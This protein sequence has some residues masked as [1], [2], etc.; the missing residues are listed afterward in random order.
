MAADVLKWAV[1]AVLVASL[2]A[3][4]YTL[5]LRDD[6]D[7]SS[8]ATP[9]PTEIPLRTPPIE[10]QG[11]GSAEAAMRLELLPVGNEVRLRWTA[12]GTVRCSLP[13]PGVLQITW[14]GQPP[15]DPP[16]MANVTRRFRV[17]LDLP[18]NDI[19]GEWTWSNWCGSVG[20]YAWDV[21]AGPP[22][23]NPG[24]RVAIDRYPACVDVT[25]PTTLRLERL[26]KGL[27]GDVTASDSCKGR[28]ADWLCQFATDVALRSGSGAI[29]TPDGFAT[30]FL[31]PLAQRP[32][33]STLCDG[34]PAG[35]ARAGFPIAVDGEVAARRGNEVTSQ[36]R[37]V[38]VF[39]D[40][41]KPQPILASIGCPVD[42]PACQ[43]VVVAFRTS[44]SGSYPVVYLVFRLTPG[45]EPGFVGAGFVSQGYAPILDGGSF[46]TIAGETKFIRLKSPG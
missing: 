42:D 24:A 40:R 19:L 20:D 36:L 18:V 8:P 4:A 25:A 13:G 30:S 27:E 17:S 32:E 16:T 23:G 35:N 14:S 44:G 46:T 10:L 31:C 43:T 3:A 6:S 45:R 9:A 22:E 33:L 7:P 11:C 15:A 12:E 1:G 5:V 29:S 28:V 2:V 34:V 21:V 37:D 39:S 26:G 41:T 38:F